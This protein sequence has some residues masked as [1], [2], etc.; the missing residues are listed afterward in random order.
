MTYKWGKKSKDLLETCDKRLQDMANM[1][2]AR[3]EFDLTITDGYR[4]EEDQN[5]AFVNGKSKARFGQSKHNVFPSQAIDICPYP[6][7]KDWDPNDRKWQ[8]MALNAM[9]CAG[10]LGFEI[11]WG[12]SFKKLVDKPHFE[13][14]G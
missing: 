4:S 8:E 12:G 14:K 3:S 7:P 9:W 11:T 6:I 10:K 1:M 13:L 2:L 5:W